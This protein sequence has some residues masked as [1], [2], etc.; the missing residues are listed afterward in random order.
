MGSSRAPGIKAMARLANV[1]EVEAGA[2]AARDLRERSAAP[3]QGTR[4]V[5][6]FARQQPPAGK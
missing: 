4:W 5:A 6:I 2:N 3:F 1:C